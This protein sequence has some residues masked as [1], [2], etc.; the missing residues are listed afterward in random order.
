MSDVVDAGR[1]D[2]GCLVVWF[3]NWGENLIDGYVENR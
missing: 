3:E 2:A 1:R